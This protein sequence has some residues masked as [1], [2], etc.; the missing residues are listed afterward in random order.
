MNRLLTSAFLLAAPLLLSA[1]AR[2]IT[3]KHNFGAFSEDLAT[4]DAVFQLVN[5][6]DKPIR[7]IDARATCGCTI[8]EYS[9]AD[10]APGDTASLKVTYAA[11][12]RPGK[13]EKNVYVKTSDAPS[14]QQTL[15]VSGVVIGASATIRSRFPADAGKIKLQSS[16]AGFGEVKRGKFKTVFISMYNQSPDSLSP[17]IEGLP[18]YITAQITPPVVAPGQQSQIALTLNSQK[19]PD[20]GIT[21]DSFSFRSAPGEEPMKM[22]FFTI[23]VE[24]FS[25]LTPGQMQNAPE[26][27]VTPLK[28]DLDAISTPQTVEFTVTNTG[29][30]PLIVRRLQIVD[31]AISEAKI[32]TDKIKPGKKAKITVTVNPAT[33]EGDFINARLSLITN[34]PNNS[35]T[36]ARVT[37]E[38]PAKQ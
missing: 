22:D 38:L 16:S 2:W 29:K 10:I 26:C 37:A 21:N 9:K 31:P 34:D 35:L 28:V 12:G 18:D 5:E 30:S 32:S 20:W 11:T 23:I 36:V 25:K 1:Q 24:D 4:V 17:V 27:H 13:F 6:S 33:A 15:T 8:P 7:I 19:V 14:V 3:Q